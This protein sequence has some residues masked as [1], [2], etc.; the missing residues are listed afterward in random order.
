MYGRLIANYT[1]DPIKITI[2]D[3]SRRELA[4][5]NLSVLKNDIEE[6]NKQST[7]DI[8]KFTGLVKNYES[9]PNDFDSLFSTVISNRQEQLDKIWNDRS[10][11][12][13]HIQ[14]D[15][16]QTIISSAKAEAQKK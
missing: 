11:M 14:P 12:L 6:F 1:D 10:D 2:T 16:W 3:E 7:Q 5:K 4:L 15:E 9:Q 8:E 13:S